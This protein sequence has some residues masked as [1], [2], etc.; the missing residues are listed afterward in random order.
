ML[1]PTG[2]TVMES[3]RLF[4][5]PQTGDILLKTIAIPLIFVAA[6]ALSGCGSTTGA[7][8]GSGTAIGLATG[9]AIGAFSA[10]AGAGALVGAGVGALGGFLVDEHRKGNL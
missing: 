6:A 7:R 2:S 8:V 1:D 5:G 10:Q 3:A 4:A 9:A